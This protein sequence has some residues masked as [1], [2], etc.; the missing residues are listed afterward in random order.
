M[1]KPD[2]PAKRKAVKS[3]KTTKA[4]TIAK[5]K[6]TVKAKKL[7]AFKEQLTKT[8]MMSYLSEDTGLSKKEV[9]LVINSLGDL[10][11]RSIKPRSC[12]A[13]SLPG[14]FKIVTVHKPAKKA[15]KGINPFTG[16]ETTF[17]AKAAHKVVKIRALKKVKDM[18]DC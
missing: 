4:K 6:T 7:S 11:E 18:V 3:T 17:K 12:G 8:Q 13:F 5:S 9:S 1:R 15:R 16:E 10:I 14:L 2:M